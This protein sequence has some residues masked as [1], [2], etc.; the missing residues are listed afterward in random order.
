MCLINYQGTLYEVYFPFIYSFGDNPSLPRMLFNFFLS[1][2]SNFFSMLSHPYILTIILQYRLR[3]CKDFIMILREMRDMNTEGIM[4]A[5]KEEQSRED[6]VFTGLEFN[7]RENTVVVNFLYDDNFDNL[8]EDQYVPH[9]VD[10]VFLNEDEMD[11]LILK[12]NEKNV[13]YHI[14]QDEFL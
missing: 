5:V 4:K 7:V 1:L 9:A 13:R 2:S 3:T 11:N 14:R 10:P 6:K 12:L 8:G